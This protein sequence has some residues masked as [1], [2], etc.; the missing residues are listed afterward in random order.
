MYMDSENPTTL[1]FDS[2]LAVFRAIL[3]MSEPLDLPDTTPLRHAICDIW[4]TLG[5]L[6][7]LV[8]KPIQRR[9]Y[10]RPDIQ[11]GMYAHYKTGNTYDVFGLARQEST[12][13]WMVLYRNP[14]T[15]DCFAR[16]AT[17]WH[18]DVNGVPRFKLAGT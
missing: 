5:D 10:P 1:K 16:P 7:G 17:E 2:P 9:I 4:P 11:N 8:Q 12:G 14:R 18:E 15:G 13:E 6:R 3:H